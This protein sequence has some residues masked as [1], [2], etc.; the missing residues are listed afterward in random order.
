MPRNCDMN[1]ADLA[2]SRFL[3]RRSFKLARDGVTVVEKSFF[4]SRR[5]H[6]YYENI[7]PKPQEIT[8]SPRKLLSASILFSVITLICIPIVLASSKAGSD[9]VAILFWGGLAA[10]FWIAFFL[11]RVSLILYVQ[12]QGGVVLYADTPSSLAVSQFVRKMFAARNTYLRAKYGQFLPD[13]PQ[14]E[15]LARLNLL[16]NQEVIDETEYAFLRRQQLSGTPES[17]GPVGFSL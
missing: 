8:V 6:V 15:K 7:P 5:Y 16:R 3:R 1:D 11:N 2:Q 12:D 14:A 9:S 13:E 17:K 10:V 4:S